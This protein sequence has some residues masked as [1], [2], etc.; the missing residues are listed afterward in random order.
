MPGFIDPASEL[1]ESFLAG[2][3]EFRSDRDY[4]VP[5][6]V[7][8]VDPQALEDSRAF[9]AYVARV[10]GERTQDGVRSGFVP[11]TTLW[12]ADGDQFLGRLAIRHQLTPELMELG[13]H[14]GYDVRPSARRRGH[15]TAMLAAALPIALKLG[16]SQALVMCDLTNAASRR[17]I[18]TNGG[19]LL[20][21]TARKRRY[22]V[23][24]AEGSTGSD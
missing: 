19:Q 8:D 5:W 10:L 3:A 11:M 20:D 24:T 13:G 9:E 14:I 4:P 15:A 12:W 6:F 16:I 1:R 23:P 2:V 7:K 21:V 22:W 17:V 18:E